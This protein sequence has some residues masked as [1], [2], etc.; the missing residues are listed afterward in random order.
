MNK[1]RIGRIEDVVKKMIP[2]VE[3]CNEHAHSH[4]SYS[5]M[6][7]KKNIYKINN[8]LEKVLAINS[9]SFN[10]TNNSKIS[11]DQNIHYGYIAQE[12][13][14]IIPELVSTDRLGYKKINYI[15]MIPILSNAIREQNDNIDKLQNVI[16]AIFLYHFIYLHVSFSPVSECFP[17]YLDFP[18]AHNDIDILGIPVLL[19]AS[20]V[21]E[22]RTP[23]SLHMTCFESRAF[24]FSAFFA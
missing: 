11:F 15:E 20:R 18:L 19:S 6:R 10:Y 22:K 4:S 1:E 12:V 23:V 2:M 7:L 8:G 24:N 5:D 21:E 3:N 17:A 16:F 9:Y 13:E 14:H